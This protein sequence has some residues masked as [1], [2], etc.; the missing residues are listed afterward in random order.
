[1]HMEKPL[2]PLN[3]ASPVFVKVYYLFIPIYIVYNNFLYHFARLQSTHGTY[4]LFFIL[5]NA[6]FN[7]HWTINGTLLLNCNYL[8]VIHLIVFLDL[9]P[10]LGFASWI[11]ASIVGKTG[12]WSYWNFGLSFNKLSTITFC[13]V[14]ISLLN[15]RNEILLIRLSWLKKDGSLLIVLFYSLFLPLNFIQQSQF[16]LLS[17]ISIS[18]I[19]FYNITHILKWNNL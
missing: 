12:S 11:F 3:H 15:K 14:T 6:F 9:I 10:Y 2:L 4:I 8:S 1:M 16:I 7:I 5:A 18:R 13:K 19:T 17:H